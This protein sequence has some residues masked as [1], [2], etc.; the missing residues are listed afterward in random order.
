MERETKILWAVVAGVALAAVLFGLGG[1]A[2]QQL[3][4]EPRAAWVAIAT[5]DNPLAVSGPVEL[6]AGAPFTLHAVLE[7]E[8][9]RG[10]RVYYTDAEALR[11][12]DQEIPTS[13]LRRWAGAE[14]V[15]I[16]WFTVEGVPPYLEVAEASDLGR[17]Q[18]R[19]SFRADWPQTWAVPGSIEPSRRRLGSGAAGARADFGTQRFHVRIEFFGQAGAVV[20]R[21]RMRSLGAAEVESGIERF[22]AVTARLAGSLGAPSAVFGTP[23]VEVA[24]VADAA[25]AA[26]VAELWRHRLVFSRLVVLRELLTRAGRPWEGLGW[27][28]V[29]LEEGPQWGD[30]GAAP[31]DV[32]RV[33]ERFVILVSDEGRRG[34]LDHGDLA[35][36]FDKGAV[37]RGLG[38]VFSGEGLVE[39]APLG[40]A[41]EGR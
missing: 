34:R 14:E 19:E 24:E 27:R 38:E 2:R 18:F 31:G 8:T 23:Q 7:A 29:D 17:L 28:A 10:E 6:I 22:P 33:G 12:G 15:R 41:T 39:W 21:L 40:S 37:L 4:P 3:A 13:A 26:K 35:F 11:L 25:L 20:P 30:G 9:W 32:L 36:D 16:L 5:G 1:K